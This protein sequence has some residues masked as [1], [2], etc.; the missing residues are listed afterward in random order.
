M[1]CWLLSMTSLS[2][3]PNLH[4]GVPDRYARIWIC[5][6]TSARNTVPVEGMSGKGVKRSERT[7][8]THAQ[9][10]RLHHIHKRLVFLVLDVRS[11]PARRPCSLGRDLRRLFLKGKSKLRA[12]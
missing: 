2:F 5:P 1:P 3:R 12:G 9:V 10:D 7:L 11:P 8:C 6:S 4:S